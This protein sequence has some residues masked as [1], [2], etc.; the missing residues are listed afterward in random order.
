MAE[1]TAT[2]GAAWAIAAGLIASFLAAVGVT[3]V[4]VFWAAAG[5]FVGAGWAPPSGRVRSML[6]F[7]VSTMLAAKAGIVCAAWFGPIGGLSAHDTSQAFG[8]LAGIAF[9]PLTAAFV[10][11]IPAIARLRTGQQE[12]TK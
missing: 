6:M 2:T 7:P 4:H 8:G 3:W 12:P 10:A 5:A 9:H 1:P 11:A